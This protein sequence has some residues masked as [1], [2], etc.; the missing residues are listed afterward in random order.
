VPS[1]GSVPERAVPSWLI[2]V[3]LSA[4]VAL[5]GVAGLALHLYTEPADDADG[6]AYLLAILAALPYLAL[7]RAPLGV[8]VTAAT[9]LV[10]QQSRGYSSGLTG[11]ALFAAAFGVAAWRDRRQVVLAAA[12]AA[13]VLAAISHL[14]PAFLAPGEVWVNAVLF[15]TALT[16]GAWARSRRLHADAL[17]ERASLAVRERDQAA[18]RA[19]AEERVRIA[20][21]LHD[22]VAHSMGMIALQ[23]GVGAHVIDSQPG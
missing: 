19:V 8:L 13:A 23:A 17:A 10:V 21:E 9:V 20:E 18:R 3:T 6:L 7:H 15:G 12:A 2:D 14:S 5:T 16:M 4:A 11:L 22:I 1:V